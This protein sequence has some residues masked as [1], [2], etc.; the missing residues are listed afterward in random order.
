MKNYYKILEVNENASIEVIDKAYR[1]LVK[2]YH[3]D[4]QG[5]TIEAQNKIKEINEAY[6]VLSDSFLKEQYDEELRKEVEKEQSNNF[7]ENDYTRFYKE[8]ERQ[9]YNTNQVNNEN[10]DIEEDKQSKKKTNEIGTGLGIINLVKTIFK[11]RP[12]LDSIKNI[13]KIDFL[14]LAL[15]IIIMIGLGVLLYVLPFTHDW[16]NENFIDT[17]L[18]N[19]FKNLF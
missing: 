5:N 8:K 7:Q 1:V 6:N 10:N 18:V 14:A 17:P 2:K 4:L 16:M 9:K 19:W 15:T 3:P 13:K 11:H 12:T